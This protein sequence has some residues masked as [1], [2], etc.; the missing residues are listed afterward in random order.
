MDLPTP[1][2]HL[3]G[4]ERLGAR[5]R[6]WAREAGVD[7]SDG[8]PR[9][10]PSSLPRFVWAQDPRSSVEAARIAREWGVPGND[11]EAVRCALDT[12]ERAEVLRQSGLPIVAADVRG[13]RFELDAFFRPDGSFVPCGV[14]AP[15]GSREDSL[16]DGAM[17]SG[18]TAED[19]RALF[20]LMES[21]ARRLG[22]E[23]GP[24]GAHAV[25]GPDGPALIEL[26]PAFRG[27]LQTCRITPIVHGRSP[28]QA[29]FAS[30]AEAGGP[31]D[32][33]PPAGD[34]TLV[35][36]SLGDA[37]RPSPP[38]GGLRSM[39]P[40]RGIQVMELTGTG[41]PR[42]VLTTS[43]W[44]RAEARERLARALRRIDAAGRIVA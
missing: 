31:F 15:A 5:V 28:V 6:A 22:L 43:G 23:H 12:A 9:R 33:L 3:V 37:T 13:S 29:W 2:I 30:L 18:L 26:L 34:E 24:L 11:P 38:A 4:P 40:G 20:S 42:W 36:R 8:S 14:M 21:A 44:D 32:L 19:E 17:P 41:E 35:F 1:A 27:E 10:P 16:A 39:T 25:L 7:L